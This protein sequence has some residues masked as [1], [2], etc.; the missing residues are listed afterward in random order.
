MNCAVNSLS[1]RYRG[2]HGLQRASDGKTLAVGA[3]GEPAGSRGVGA[4]ETGSEAPA[5]GAAYVFTFQGGAWAQ[6]TFIKASNAESGDRFGHNVA[7]SADGTVLTVSAPWEASKAT[8]LNGVEG[9]N[10]EP[11]SGAVYRFL[12]M[13]NSWVQTHYLKASNA[14]ADD[15]FGVCLAPN[16]KS[17]ATG[18]NGDQQDNSVAGAGAAYVFQWVT[19]P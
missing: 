13:G 10:S 1:G 12:R 8:G 18:L 7:L 3:K 17:A 14:Q 2:A 16:E 11:A 5:A 19:T 6:Q 15:L 4:T 9:N